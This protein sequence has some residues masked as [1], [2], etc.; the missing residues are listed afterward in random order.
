MMW[1]G[2]TAPA[3]P[4]ACDTGRK[5]F[6]ISLDTTDCSGAAVDWTF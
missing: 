3:E 5:N 1:P 2:E 6:K 4:A